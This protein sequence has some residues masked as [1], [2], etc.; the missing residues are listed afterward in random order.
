MEGGAQMLTTWQ[1]VSLTKEHL[2]VTAFSN[3]FVALTVLQLLSPLQGSTLK[4]QFLFPSVLPIPFK[5]STNH[6]K[7]DD[8]Q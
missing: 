8:N 5:A 7:R 3:P 4:S 1:T 2:Q 6:P